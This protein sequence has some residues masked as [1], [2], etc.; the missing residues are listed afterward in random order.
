MSG[1]KWRRRRGHAG[2]SPASQKWGKWLDI[3]MGTI[4]FIFCPIPASLCVQ[5]VS[6][7]TVIDECAGGK[8]ALRHYQIA[9]YMPH[10]SSGPGAAAAVMPA[11]GTTTRECRFHITPSKPPNHTDTMLFG[12][13][14]SHVILEIAKILYFTHYNTLILWLRRLCWKL[15]F[16]VLPITKVWT[17]SWAGLWL[18]NRSIVRNCAVWRRCWS[19]KTRRSHYVARIIS[20][21]R[22][23]D[24]SIWANVGLPS[25]YIHVRK[26]MSWK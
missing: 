25:T 23:S 2:I 18:M 3:I 13:K 21:L 14:R 22:C 5:K 4:M 10:C 12:H 16:V 8:A 19:A 20:L 6:V 26:V 1:L 11:S 9:R 7:M 17:K 15:L 24:I